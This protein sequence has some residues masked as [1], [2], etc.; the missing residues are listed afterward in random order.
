MRVEA[1][2][3]RPVRKSLQIPGRC[4]GGLE[5][6][7]SSGSVKYGWIWDMLSQQ[8]FLINFTWDD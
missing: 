4:D 7:D 5:W 1:E 2:A 8:Y 6:E 3:K